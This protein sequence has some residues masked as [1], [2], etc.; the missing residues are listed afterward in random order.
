MAQQLPASALSP[1]PGWPLPPN[2]QCNR[3][4][5]AP[6]PAFRAATTHHLRFLILGGS[7]STSP[8]VCYLLYLLATHPAALARVRAEHNAN[9][10]SDASCAAALLMAEPRHLNALP[11]SNTDI[12]ETLRLFAPATSIRRS[13]PSPNGI[14]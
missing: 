10:G 5:A 4:P 3:H 8:A 2:A 12:K 13:A 11:Y 6:N 14:L 7:V 9:L 1:A